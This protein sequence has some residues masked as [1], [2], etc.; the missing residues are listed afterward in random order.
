VAYLEACTSRRPIENKQPTSHGW[1]EVFFLPL[2]F[3]G[4]QMPTMLYVTIEP[5]DVPDMEMRMMMMKAML[6]NITNADS[7]EGDLIE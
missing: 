3:T 7:D 5:D 2:W 4:S 1:K 6:V